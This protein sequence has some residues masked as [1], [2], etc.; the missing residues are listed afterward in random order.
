[1]KTLEGSCLNQGFFV[2]SHQKIE[3]RSCEPEDFQALQTVHCQPK[4]IWGTLQLPFPSVERWKK[5]LAERPDDQSWLVACV[6]GRVVGSLG[7]AVV[8]RSP[9]RRHVGELGM[10][11]HDEWHAQGVGSALMDAAL[12]LADRWLN[13]TRLELTVFTD[14]VPAIR[15]YKRAG[16]EIEGRFHKYAFRDGQF[17][18]VFAMARIR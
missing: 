17:A 1:M 15:L 12:N 14:N 3:I 13:L 5:R 10:A 2:M 16:F 9:R 7:L 6:D 4:A 11:V 18:D 8:T